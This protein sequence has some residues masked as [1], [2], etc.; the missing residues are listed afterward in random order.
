MRSL[1]SRG[2]GRVC[3]M[4]TVAS[5]GA[6]RAFRRVRL[7]CALP[8]TVPAIALRSTIKRL[9]LLPSSLLLPRALHGGGNKILRA[10]KVAQQQQCVQAAAARRADHP[11]IRRPASVAA[12]RFTA[13]HVVPRTRPVC[14]YAP[15]GLFSRSHGGMPTL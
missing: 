9:L 2:R 10:A 3:Q 7:L 14:L 5:V 6:R 1:L 4:S 11:I 12:R 15:S 8:C 13:V